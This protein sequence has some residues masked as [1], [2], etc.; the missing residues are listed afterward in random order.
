MQLDLQLYNFLIRSCIIYNLP[1]LIMSTLRRIDTR[2]FISQEKYITFLA[3]CNI[4]KNFALVKKILIIC[5]LFV[6]YTI[7]LS[8]NFII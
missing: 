3:I 6:F 1:Y 4:V 2:N 7:V 5:C 8:N